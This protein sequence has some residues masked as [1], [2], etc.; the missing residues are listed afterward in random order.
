MEIK[1]KLIDVMHFAVEYM[2]N[3]YYMLH[4]V[5]IVD[6]ITCVY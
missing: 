1:Y 5:I 3:V 6:D 2:M 4:N